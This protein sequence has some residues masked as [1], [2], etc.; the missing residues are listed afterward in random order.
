MSLTDLTWT[1]ALF[2]AVLGVEGLQRLVELWVSRQRQVQRGKDGVAPVPETA[3]GFMIL[4]HVLLF[5]LP[6]LEVL[7]LKRPFLWAVGGPALVLYALAKV[8]RWWALSTLGRSW[9]A[10]IVKPNTVVAEGPY[11]FI[12]HPNYLVVITEL[13]VI[14]LV[15]TAWLSAVVLSV[16]N[17]LVLFARIRK[18]EETLF[19]IPGYREVMGGKARF[20]PGLF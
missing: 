9:N 5:V 14:P 16:V 10:R 19:S 6:P 12:R 15:H 3:W 20:V 2:A 1:H 18:E 7:L 11:R 4:V 17:G 8:L 13:A